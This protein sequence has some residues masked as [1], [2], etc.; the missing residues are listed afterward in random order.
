MPLHGLA[1][2]GLRVA[3]A[4]M[5]RALRKPLCKLLAKGPDVV[6]QHVKVAPPE[7]AGNGFCDQRQVH[8][9]AVNLL[10]GFLVGDAILECLAI[11]CSAN[12][13]LTFQEPPSTPNEGTPAPITEVGATCLSVELWPEFDQVA[14]QEGLGN[15]RMLP[16]LLNIRHICVINCIT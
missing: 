1:D 6:A 13:I 9:N 2:I 7:F 5:A 8:A 10:G 16:T 12:R 4:A 3:Q 15:A 14:D 11:P